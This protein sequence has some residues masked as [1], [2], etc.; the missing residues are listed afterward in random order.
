MNIIFIDIETNGLDY[1]VHVPI[2]IAMLIA[3][4][5]QP[6]NIISY[7]TK[8]RCTKSQW[9]KSCQESL[10]VN[11]FTYANLLNCPTIQDTME[12]FTH[13]F[14]NN[15]INKHNSVFMCQNPSFD[16]PFFHKIISTDMCKKLNLPYHWLD[17]ASMFW[18]KN[19]SKTCV[20]NISIKKDDIA[21]ELGIPPEK[22]PHSAYDGAKHLMDCYNALV[23]LQAN[24]KGK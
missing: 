2:E 16:R 17:L 12:N 14:R 1:N 15:E 22:K 24:D 20:G 9:N 4:Q 13:I 7:H 5:Q 11:K 21:K 19:T 3:N 8:I 23:K 6:H 10:D 18:F